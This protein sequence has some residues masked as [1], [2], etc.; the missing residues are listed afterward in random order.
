MAGRWFDSIAGWCRSGCVVSATDS[1]SMQ[2]EVAAPPKNYK[3]IFDENF[4]NLSKWYLVVYNSAGGS[5]ND[6][7]P[8]LDT[9][10][11]LPAP[12]LDENGDSWCG[13]GVYTKETF[14]YTNGLVIEFDMYVASGYDWNWG[15]C[16]L[17]DHMPNLNNPRP[18]GAYVDPLRCDPSF[19]AGIHFTDDGSYNRNP[20]SLRFVIKTEDETGDGYTYARDASEFQNKWNHY[21]I[22]DLTVTWNFT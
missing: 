19:V 12:S 11:G 8:T 13:N 21:K 17:S 15:W 22:S 20:P 9:T 16:G 3:I 14:D 10:M 18:D 6:P 2:V 1:T 7:A 4:E 5:E